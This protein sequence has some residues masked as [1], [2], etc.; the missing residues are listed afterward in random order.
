M[1]VA[2]TGATGLVGRFFTERAMAEG[3]HVTA[4]TRRA[5][6]PGFFSQAARHQPYV[7]GDSPD[8]SDVHEVI[9]CAFSHIPGR[10]RG[11]EGDDPQGFVTA[12][13][14]GSETLFHAAKQAGVA[15]VFF[16]SSRAVYGDF[17]QPRQLHEEQAP[18][19]ATLYGEVKWQAEQ[20]LAALSG[21]GFTGIALRAT[22]VYGPA[23]PGQRHKWANLFDDYLKGWPVPPRRGTEVHGADLAQVPVLL[24]K[25]PAG[26]YNVSDFLLD[27]RA[28]LAQVARLTG[29][30]NPLPPAANDAFSGMTTEK[31]QRH[32]W[33][34]GGPDLLSASLPGLI[35]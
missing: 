5:P 27:R 13:L 24:R 19:P 7:L 12:N 11:G 15:R 33:A 18:H 23:G 21:G 8:L 2:I 26:A 32:G 17:A 25:A 1:R 22:G 3:H 16:L 10:Y 29:C 4:L 31:L 20:T 30:T 35:K 6:P 14:A 28:L 9:H 34:P